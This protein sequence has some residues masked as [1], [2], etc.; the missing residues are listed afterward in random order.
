MCNE[1][2]DDGSI[3]LKPVGII[4]SRFKQYNELSGEDPGKW[5]EKADCMKQHNLLGHDN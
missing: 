1:D 5:R 4:K 3:R 2:M